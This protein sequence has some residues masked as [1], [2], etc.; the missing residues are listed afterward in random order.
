MK[1][2]LLRWCGAELG[3]N[4]SIT[5]SVRFHLTGRLVIGKDTW[6][7]HQVLIVGGNADVIIGERVDIAPRVSLVTGSHEMFTTEGKAAGQGYS[8]PIRIESGAWLGASSTV[9]A[10]TGITIGE[11]AMVAAGSLVNRDIPP[12]SVVGGVPAKLLRANVDREAA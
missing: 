4:V 2:L 3:T 1:R 8:A 9:I 6:I 12:R 10:G 7:G 11:C 5:S